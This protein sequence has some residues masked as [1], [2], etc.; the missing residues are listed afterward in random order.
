MMVLTH[1][2]GPNTTKGHLAGCLFF[3]RRFD[4]LFPVGW[5]TP[6]FSS[7][8][9]NEDRF[10]RRRNHVTLNLHTGFAACGTGLIE[11]L[12]CHLHHWAPVHS[13]HQ[14]KEIPYCLVQCCNTLV[15]RGVLTPSLPQ[16][17]KFWAGRRTNTP[18]NGIFS[19]PI[20]LCILTKLLSHAGA[21]K[22]KK[23]IKGFKF[24]TLFV[25]LKGRHGSEGVN[26][27]VPP[28]VSR[29]VMR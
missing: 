21:K 2:L 26:L 5:C 3:L 8:L 13:V 18:A 22:K 27:L 24:G 23:R 1:R 20:T 4:G 28:T 14:E 6:L 10:C 7:Q 15:L 12:P 29:G 19:G 9:A 16:H 11:T 17:V 25:V